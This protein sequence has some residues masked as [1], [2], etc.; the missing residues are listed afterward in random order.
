MKSRFMKKTLLLCCGIL[1]ASFTSLAQSA[2]APSIPVKPADS[3]TVKKPASKAKSYDQV[4]TKEAKS[5]KGLFSTHQV[6]DKF[7]FEIPK[8][9]LG[10]DMLLVSQIAKLPSG[11]GGGYVNAGTS[12][13]EQL[14]VWEKFQEKILIKV[15]SY[16]SVAADS[17]PISLSVKANNY[18]PTLYMFDIET[19]SK[20][21]SN[22]VIDVTKFYSSD[23]PAMS[24]LDASLRETHKVKNLDPTRSFIRSVKSFPLNIE[25]LQDFTYN[26]SKP[27][28]T[29]Y[30]ETIS[31]Q[32]NQSMILLPEKPMKPRLFDQ[33]VGFFTQ[34]QYD[35]SSEE[36][37]SD[38]KTY[39]QRWRL[40][41]KDMAAYKRGELVEPIKPI[42][43]YLD[44]ATPMKLREH[45]KKGVENWQKAFEA[46][47]FKNAII[48]KDPPTPAEDP[49]FSP[50]DIRYSVIRYVASTTRNATGPSVSDPRS[51][52]IIESD[53]IWYHNHLR[54]YRNRFLL[55]TGAANPNARTLNTRDEDI[56]EMM[57]MV[58]SHEVG[59]ALG[60]PHN[61]GAS[62]S[63]EVE[64]YRKADFT[65]KEGISASIMDYARFNY[66]AQLGD[67]GV[68][69]IRK[70]GPYDDYAVN[71]GY[72]VLP[73]ALSP[74][75]EVPTLNKW[76][77]AKAGDARFRFGNQGTTFDPSS[78]TE[79]V[80]NDPVRASIYAVKN[81]K[82]V[83]KNLADW[84]SKKTND[85]E[86]LIELNDELLSAWSR[87]VGHVTTM[88][89]G[90]YEQYAKPNQAISSYNPVP[91]S[92]QQAAV[93]WLISNA[94]SNV[95]WLINKEV[96][97]H[98]MAGYVDR[99]RSLQVS[100][101]NRMLSL[102]TF[103]RLD[104]SGLTTPNTY[105][106]IDLFQDLRGGIWSE[107]TSGKNID[108]YRRN[109]QKAYIERLKALMTDQAPAPA[110]PN[111]PVRESFP[112]AQSD[113][114]SIVR[115][116]LKSLQTS[117]TFAKRKFT[118][119]E[120]RYHLDDC[121]DRVSLILNPRK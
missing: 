15:K 99:I 35:Y 27:S 93:N 68:R 79:D 41:P 96:V 87:Y 33:R 34:K 121:L 91:K 7:Y 4:I 85:Y 86:D 28:A 49:D 74:E 65:N 8:K 56:G 102:E 77:E 25:V 16:A 21:S 54:S 118:D 111:G 47:G 22:V 70:M 38:Q 106:T 32:M 23:I 73:D 11:I 81:L 64:N 75:D 76:V 69:F 13:H 12:S 3:S 108:Q 9:L 120:V 90:V 24:A 82:Y 112:V 101:L 110:G 48:C 66:I 55:E 59:H 88:V 31:L 109:L 29:A 103:A 117:L 119:K 78:Q 17:L 45:M 44:P 80:G 104:N 83:A 67:Q 114:R 50:E 63:Y 19:Y 26:A 40:E 14:I 5:K 39:I 116:E 94:F 100:P 43:Y 2:K 53:I 42:V 61:M 30:T 51:G 89:G 10:K 71:W 98:H 20:D 92:S 37:K 105:K 84:T 115:G 113:V 18:E 95:D 72:R 52:E 107:L 46:A 36:L 1:A 57:E 97:T 62:S 58:I 60:F 6:G